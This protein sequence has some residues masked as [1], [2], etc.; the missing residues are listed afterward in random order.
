MT[1]SWPRHLPPTNPSSRDRVSDPDVED[2]ENILDE[3]AALR[4]RQAF[5][6]KKLEGMLTAREEGL[7]TRRQAML[8]ALE[9]LE[10]EN[11]KVLEQNHE[12][13]R[14]SGL[15]PVSEETATVGTHPLPEIPQPPSRSSTLLAPVA[16]VKES[17]SSSAARVGP[18]VQAMKDYGACFDAIL[19]WQNAN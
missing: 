12:F 9:E 10:A 8:A 4:N 5:L 11:K 7:K 15:I 16:V 14:T 2:I 17:S 6:Q 1:E 18:R 19:G 3:L 13:R